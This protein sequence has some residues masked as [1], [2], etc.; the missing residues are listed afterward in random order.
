VNSNFDVVIIGSGAG[1]SPIAYELARAG[2]SVLVLEKGPLMRT[3]GDSERGAYSLSDFKRDELFNAGTERIIT[4]PDMA[5][6]GAPFFASHVEPDLNDEPHIYSNPDNPGEGSR[7]TIEGYTAQVVGGGTQLYGA[8]SLRF[9]ESDFKL[10]TVNSGIGLKQDPLGDALRFVIDWPI[11]YNDL[12]PYYE[13][14][15]E[16]VGINGTVKGQAKPFNKDLYQEPL[17]PNPIS[18]VACAGMSKLGF[19]AYRTPLAVITEDHAP[20]KRK[21]GDPKTGYV[22]RYGDPLGYKSNT[23][24]SLLK[25]TL[26]DHGQFLEIRPNSV[27]T[28]LETRG[29]HVSKVHYRDESGR[30][31]SVTG[32]LVVVACSAVESVRLIMLSAEEDLMG[33][34]NAIRYKTSESLL[35]RFFLTHA[36]GGA[37]VAL[38]GKRY[39][40][41]M[42]L[43]SDY[44]TDACAQ[45]AFIKPR[46]MWAGGAIYN[47]TSDQ[48]LPITLARN[49]G[50]T[51][52]DT[53]WSGFMGAVH[54]RERG[55][56]TWLEQ[57]FGTRLSVSFMANQIPR[58]VNRIELHPVLD[59]WNRKS[60]HVVKNWHPH[61]GL[62]MREMALACEDILLR[63]AEASGIDKITRDDI[64][65]GS[66][67]GNGVRIANHILGGMRF[68]DDPS[69]SVLDVNCQMRGL[70]NLFVTDGS[71]MPTSGGAN[72]TLTI[73]ANAFR[74][75][76][77][78]KKQV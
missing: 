76:E 61:D 6:T 35:G 69:N 74:V 11:T 72:P 41:S 57:D 8:V 17:D 5:N 62:V 15:E 20:S 26:D 9:A 47:N 56:R 10:A 78:L 25:P 2:K 45:D 42:S 58:K 34:G 59:K 54:K 77:Y 48:S 67:Y 21:A 22:N 19:D 53:N 50:S 75:A 68:G 44:A 66:V 23:W 46:G 52:L 3:Q 30:K 29:A 60:A 18:E 55:V 38:K 49:D 39:D 31:Q 36:F 32:T 65:E 71:F 70:D 24:V 33:F 27:V 64:E 14:A 43:D 7:V 12:L 51:D 13:K 73:Q 40:K 4:V 28:H 1:G 37:E 16:L 63:G